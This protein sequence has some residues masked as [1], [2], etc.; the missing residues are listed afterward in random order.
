MS[1]LDNMQKII[2][3]GKPINPNADKILTELINRGIP[4]LDY[5]PNDDV[6]KAIF[7]DAIDE[8]LSATEI[9]IAINNIYNSGT[10][11]GFPVLLGNIDYIA[12][13]GLNSERSADLA[14]M[15]EATEEKKMRRTRKKKEKQ[16]EEGKE[17]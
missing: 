13:K 17:V 6:E 9:H 8:G 10:F 16:D 4:M 7:N 11:K 5:F 2:D 15:N 12:K 3:A 1:R 14:R